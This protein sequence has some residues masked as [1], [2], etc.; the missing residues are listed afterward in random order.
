[1]RQYTT[2]HKILDQI[3]LYQ[4][5]NPQLN[6]FGYGN[7]IDFGKNVS[8]TTVQYPY[9]FVVP[10]GIQYEEN[11]TLYQLSILFV[12]RLN[13]TL[14]NEKDVISDQS[15]NARNFL[16]TIK[17]GFLS[18]YFEIDTPVQAIPFVERFNDN[19][20][21]VALDLNLIVFEDMNACDSYVPCDEIITQYVKGEILQNQKVIR[22]SLWNDSGFTSPAQAICQ[23]DALFSFTGSMGTIVINEVEKFDEGEHNDVYNAS[24][25]LQHDEVLVNVEI[26]SVIPQC[27]CINIV[28][29][30]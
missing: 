29:P 30:T 12:D 28:L 11:T 3:E 20:G 6:S 27:P 4:K 18:E 26:V 9:L 13:D 22:G 2:Y 1:M 17:R 23:Y 16:S 21:G 24:N 8:G 7:L 15:L 19:V 25:Q 10:Q 14:D 5:T